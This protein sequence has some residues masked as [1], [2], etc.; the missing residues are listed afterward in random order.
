MST[1]LAT[2]GGTGIL[3]RIGNENERGY[4]LK[5]YAEMLGV[6][7]A[8]ADRTDVV[9]VVAQAAQRSV[10]FGW[11]PGVH[12]H[13]FP[14]RRKIRAGEESDGGDGK[15]AEY[16]LVDG[17]KA[18][19]DSAARWRDERGVKWA[20]M[21][22]PMTVAEIKNE[23][24]AMGVD[25]T[26]QCYGEYCKIVVQDEFRILAEI[27]GNEAALDSIPW[28]AGVYTGKKKIGKF[29]AEDSLPTGVSVKDVA[30][31]R[32]GKRALMQSSLTLI[33]LDN[34]TESQRVRQITD[35]LRRE[36]E[37]QQ[38]YTALP[39][40]TSPSLDDDCVFVVED[41]PPPAQK[42]KRIE[43]DEFQ[44]DKKRIAEKELGRL[45]RNAY[46]ESWRGA[47][48]TTIYNVTLERTTAPNE[49]TDD[50]FKT[51]KALVQLD[52][53]GLTL[54]D[55][56]WWEIHHG[57]AAEFE[58]DSIYLLTVD[59]LRQVYKTLLGKAEPA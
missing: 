11:Q 34:H 37:H 58:Q 15:I 4:L 45:A 42:A 53:L 13:V 23:C 30:R 28:A 14:F 1:E 21:Y 18:W 44:E 12:M 25:Y 31:R 41:T 26:Q 57:Y 20:P 24:A 27:I 49:L 33:P 19:W 9:A 8:V 48:E 35:D 59:E 51:V 43:A 5:V 32:A 6:P 36:A 54:H 22:K 38:K 17:E 46:G 47:L 7:S 29:W 55:G 40:D 50:E 16:T 3:Q 56:Q 2:T 10:Q 39:V 52:A